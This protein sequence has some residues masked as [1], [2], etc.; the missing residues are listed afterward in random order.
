MQNSSIAVR[1][2][3]IFSSFHRPA[4]KVVLTLE[5]SFHSVKAVAITLAIASQEQLGKILITNDPEEL[6]PE[7][8]MFVVPL[9]PLHSGRCLH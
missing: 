9:K 5:E 3:Q 4:C 8:I 7:I 1:T 2:A 6:T